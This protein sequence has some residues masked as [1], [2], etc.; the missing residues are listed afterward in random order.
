LIADQIIKIF[1]FNCL[2]DS[3]VKFLSLR[4]SATML[5]HLMLVGINKM[6]I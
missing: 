5:R 2:W 6:N 4:L 1:V 3:S